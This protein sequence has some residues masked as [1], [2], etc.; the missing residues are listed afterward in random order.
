LTFVAPRIAISGALSPV[1]DVAGDSFDY[2]VNGDVAH[3]AVV[4]AMGHGLQATLLSAVAMSAFRNARRSGHSLADTVER[5]GDAIA[6]HFGSDMFVT[7]L[8]GE[9][10]LRTG[11]WSWVTCGHPP[12]LLLRDGRVVKILDRRISP[13]LGLPSD[14]YQ[15]DTERLEPGDRLLLYTDG[16]T[17]ARDRAGEFFGTDRL[18]DLVVRA[19]GAGMPAPETLRRLQAA[20]LDHQ[21][22]ELQDDATVVVVEW[23]TDEVDASCS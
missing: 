9:L 6:D 19:A 7:A 8:V 23:C 14:G 22:G 1:A 13:P 5:M 21:D 15:S 16:V 18:S 3:V 20:I 12:A 11:L 17:E 2:A 10:D 4:D